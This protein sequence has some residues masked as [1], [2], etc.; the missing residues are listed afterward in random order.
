MKRVRFRQGLD[1][2]RTHTGFTPNRF[3]VLISI[4]ARG[5]QPCNIFLTHR[6]NL[7][8]P[9]PQGQA[10]RAI[11]LHHIVPIAGVDA[12]GAQL[13]PMGAGITDNLCRRIKPHGLRIQQ[14]TGKNAWMMIFK[15]TG[16]I[17]QKRKTGGMAFRKPIGPKAFNLRKTACGKIL[18][19]A[20]ALHAVHEECFKFTDI[21]MLFKRRQRSPQT[22][23]LLWREARSHDC[24]LHGLFLK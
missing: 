4:A 1:H 18:F 17:D 20:I 21:A 2:F 19:I 3:Y 23:G 24:N 12:N 5:R 16:R 13:H 15:P 9:K 10:A 14:R 11:G 7:P 22:I 8:K 6:L